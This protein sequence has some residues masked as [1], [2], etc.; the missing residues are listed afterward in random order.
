[1]YKVE[2]RFMFILER[3]EART[4]CIGEVG[5]GPLEE[6]YHTIAEADQVVNVDHQ[7]HHPGDQTGD[8]Q[9]TDFDDGV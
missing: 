2:L 9:L 6:R 1:M 5:P 7:P 8:A 4:A 3:N